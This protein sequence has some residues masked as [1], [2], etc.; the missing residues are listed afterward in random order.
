[1]TSFGVGVAVTGTANGLT[2]VRGFGDSAG[3]P[4]K[5]SKPPKVGYINPAKNFRVLPTI[6]TKKNSRGKWGIFCI[7]CQRAQY[8]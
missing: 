8:F 3:I 2:A 4:G 5:T 6:M 1:M 7:L